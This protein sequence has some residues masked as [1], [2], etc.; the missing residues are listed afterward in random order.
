MND[1]VQR[2]THFMNILYDAGLL[3]KKI[4]GLS[5]NEDGT[6]YIDLGVVAQD[7]MKGYNNVVYI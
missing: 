5:I 4:M 1:G 2:E 3:T 7:R 6:S